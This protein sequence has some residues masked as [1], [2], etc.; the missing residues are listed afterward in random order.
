MDRRPSFTTATHQRLTERWTDRI[1]KRNV[2]Y[3]SI[4]EIGEI[5]APFRPGEKLID[6]H[7]IGWA[8][9]LLQRADGADADNAA[10]AEF[11]QRVDVGE[12]VQFAWQDPVSRLAARQKRKSATATLTGEKLDGRL[13]G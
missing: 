10:D 4:A 1:S 13:A 11:L 7:D 8:I 9:L 3:D 6:D 5:P 2:G 12:L